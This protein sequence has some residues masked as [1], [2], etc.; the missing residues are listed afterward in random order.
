M[1]ST[2]RLAGERDVLVHGRDVDDPP[3]AAGGDHPPRGGARAGTRRSRS[4]SRMWRHVSSS[5]SRTGVT[6]PVPALLTS[7]SR[8][9]SASA[10]SST[11][12]GP[13][14]A[15]RSSRRTRRGSRS[16]HLLRGL[17]GAGVVL[18]PRDADV[19][20][21]ARERD[22]GGLA[23]PG[24]RAGA[25]ATRALAARDDRTRGS[26]V[27]GTGAAATI[28]SASSSAMNPRAYGECAVR[29]RTS[30]QS[31]CSRRARAIASARRSRAR[32]RRTRRAWTRRRRSPAAP[33]SAR[34]ARTAPRRA[35]GAPRGSEALEVPDQVDEDLAVPG[36]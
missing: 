36:P 21:V 9:P 26:P 11:T 25:I 34:P 24:V 32:A 33:A 14:V 2:A 7:T 17:L 4:V 27:R 5:I 28:S 23:D 8:P 6:S 20:A 10:S 30:R 29:S 15:S 1:A 35:P 16:A 22:R 3:A 18:V 19:V 12:G 31:T 13:F